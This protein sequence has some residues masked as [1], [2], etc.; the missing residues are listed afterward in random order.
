[1]IRDFREKHKNVILVDTGDFLW[2]RKLSE[3]RAKVTARGLSIMGYDALNISDGEL[4]YGIDFLQGFGQKLKGAFVSSNVSAQEDLPWKPY[5]I[6]ELKGVKVAI[7]G[8]ISYDLVNHVQMREDGV[9]VEDQEACLTRL[10]PDVREKA[11]LVVLLSHLGWKQTRTLLEKVPGIDI[12]I[13]GHAH[14]PTLESEKIGQAILLKNSIG[15][16]HLGIV[17]IWLD[18]S[19]K[20]KIFKSSLKELSSDVHVYSEDTLFETEF[21]IKK[22][23]L[24]RRKEQAQKEKQMME[25]FKDWTKLSPEEFVKKMNREK[26]KGF[27]RDKKEEKEPNNCHSDSFFHYRR[28]CLSFFRVQE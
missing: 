16:K 18:N 28:L 14:F 2:Q 8:I 26:G 6:K 11:D 21:E 3:L 17:K 5:I 4:S 1:M 25:Q 27:I 7:L 24:N 13:V 12:A 9:S 23:G 10:L 19:K 22:A 15:G 20:I